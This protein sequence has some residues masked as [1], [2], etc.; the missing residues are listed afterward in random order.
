[1]SP[2][3]AIHGG[4]SAPSAGAAEGRDPNLDL[5]RWRLLLAGALS[6]ITLLMVLVGG[7]QVSRP[8]MVGSLGLLATTLAVSWAAAMAAAPLRPLLIFQL[9]A[10]TVCL[11]LLVH[12][13]GGPY[14]ALP[15]VYCVPIML[16]ASFLD[17][18]WAVATAGLAA[19]LTGGGH[20]GLALGWLLTGVASDLDYLSGW[21]VVVTA[22]HM[23]VF[24]VCGMISA[25]QARRLAAR[26][27]EKLHS[28]QRVL[29]S[30]CE[31]RNV[32]D[33]LRSGLITVDT[34]GVVTR[35]NPA[36]CEILRLDAQHMLGERL[37][38]VLAD[39]M[40]DLAAIILPVA[41]GGPPVS[42][43]EVTVRCRGRLTPLGMNVNPMIDHD[44][45]VIGAIMIFADLTHEKEMTERLRENDRLA[46][47]GELSASIAH[48]IRNPLASI[49]GSVEMLAGEL[50]LVGY[51][52]QLLELVLKE[53]GRVNTIINDF[54][55]Y[56]RMRPS[57][58]RRFAAADF[59][60]EI[61]LLIEQHVAAKNG[62]V[63]V[64]CELGSED[65]AVAADPGQLTQM[66]LNLAINSCEAMHYRG[67]LRL[68]L[69][70]VENA[71]SC[72]LVVTDNGPG[73]EDDIRDSLFS[74]FKTTKEGGTGLGLSVVARIVNAHGGTVRAEEAPGGGAIFRARWPM[75]RT[76]PERATGEAPTPAAP[77]TEPPTTLRLPEPVA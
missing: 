33:S 8:G 43:G 66:A 42:R 34:R 23:S 51:Q 39:G 16:A 47:I 3:P 44:G 24:V 60:D 4:R 64:S 7:V 48:E 1:M 9:T 28:D 36:C 77:A 63:R 62:D 53:S 32:V 15:L 59:R 45:A 12:F 30:Q 31:L 76:A 65:M 68:A 13:S 35:V 69:N 50:D 41:C 56:S 67:R 57:A 52:R 14:S 20:F 61:L 25:D 26:R 75:D 11:G 37:E 54:L 55:A 73:I 70:L 27:A 22:L 58:V 6:L 49:R 71:E 21:P 29:R 19:I 40:E 38:L 72:E 10:D 74:P 2:L 5:L 46:A 18:R 17:G